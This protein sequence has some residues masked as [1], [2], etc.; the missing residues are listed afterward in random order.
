MI[1]KRA[2]RSAIFVGLACLLLILAACSREQTGREFEPLALDQ[3]PQVLGRGFPE[4]AAVPEGQRVIVGEDAPDF[5]FV[6]ADDH[7]T[8]LVDLT[9][10]PV[11]INFWATWC[12]PCRQEM[13]D[14]VALHEENPDLIVLAVNLQ[15]D[16]ERVRPFAEEFAMTMPVILDTDGNI[17]RAYGVRGLP[18]TIFIN[19]E[20]KIASRWDGMLTAVILAERVSMLQ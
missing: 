20:R 10:K 4:V 13:P 14:L 5:S 12:G 16:L 7:G 3:F 18:V 19:S 1:K 8:S 15:E 2:R 11:V 17:G 6:L 9:G